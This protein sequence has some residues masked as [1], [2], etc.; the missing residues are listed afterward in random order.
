MY[1]AVISS[2][3]RKTKFTKFVS[4]AI[5]TARSRHTSRWCRIPMPASPRRRA[6]CNRHEARA[7]TSCCLVRLSNGGRGPP[8]EIVSLP[9]CTQRSICRGA[10]LATRLDP[11]A[12]SGVKRGRSKA[13]CF[14][15]LGGTSIS[16][17][18]PVS[19][20]ATQRTG[21]TDKPYRCSI[22]FLHA[23][24]SIYTILMTL[25]HLAT[26]LFSLM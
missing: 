12:F 9:A 4:E 2:F 11:L 17:P 5:A 26:T 15:V 8:T 20:H 7:L 3:S 19:F 1:V 25:T 14:A 18:A 16:D 10:A 23:W 24:R 21:S 13:L 6:R 22:G